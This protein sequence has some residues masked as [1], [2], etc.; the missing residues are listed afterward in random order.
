LVAAA[1]DAS[2]L[3]LGSQ[4][5]W[6]FP[7]TTDGN[8]AGYEPADGAAAVNHLEAQRGRGVRYFVLP[9]PAYSWRYRYPDLLEYLAHT[10]RR[11]H[12]DEPLV[13]YHLAPDATFVTD[14]TPA[15]RVLVRG[16]FGAGR[17]GPS[18]ALIAELRNSSRLTV[19]QEWRADD[20]DDADA[21]PADF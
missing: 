16:T 14:P 11:V 2:L 5:S 17:A 13:V 10:A 21:G 8:V 19:T 18:P 9:K 3:E 20:D 6:P 4:P 12:E 1:G 7:Q 15:A